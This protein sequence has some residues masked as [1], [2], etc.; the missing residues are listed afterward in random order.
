MTYGSPT[1]GKNRPLDEDELEFVD[2]I[3]QQEQ[4][5]EKGQQLEESQQ[6]EAFQQVGGW[7]ERMHELPASKVTAADWSGVPGKCNHVYAPA[8]ELAAGQQRP[9]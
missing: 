4:M 1:A 2:Q 6:L 8:S 3:L 5:K 7:H 9:L